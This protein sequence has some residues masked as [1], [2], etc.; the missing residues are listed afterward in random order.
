MNSG[1]SLP[2]RIALIGYGKMGK[3]I[4]EIAVLH[5]H[6]I[7]LK[8]TSKN[9][10]ELDDKN[11]RGCDVAIEFTGPETALE[12]IRTCINNGVPVISG[13]TGWLEHLPQIKKLCVEKNATFLYASNFSIGVNIF[14]AV[15]QALANLMNARPEYNV[16]IEEIHHTAKK[17]APSGTAITL[18]QDII[19]TISTYKKWCLAPSTSSDAIEITSK[20]IDPAS[21]THIIKYTSLVDDIEI[22]HTAHSRKGFAHGALIAAEYVVGKKGIYT[23]SD[24]LNIDR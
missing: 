21:G 14:F 19:Q 1:T 3:A 23:M 7:V 18:A 16:S 24:V 11:L 10:N 9:I 6:E 12:N 5:G 22:C 8:I 20:R 13:S 2:L 15:N 17:D 4:E